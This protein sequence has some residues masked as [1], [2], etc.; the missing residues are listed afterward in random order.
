VQQIHAYMNS[1]K[2][3]KTQVNEY[4]IVGDNDDVPRACTGK[5]QC[6]NC[7]LR[8]STGKPNEVSKQ[9]L[10]LHHIRV[11]DSNGDFTE[12]EVCPRSLAVPTPIFGNRK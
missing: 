10:G 11:E 7:S 2:R 3:C 9:H 4:V 8:L 6:W 12:Y 1:S 5:L